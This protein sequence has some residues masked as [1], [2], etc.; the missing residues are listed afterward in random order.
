MNRKNLRLELSQLSSLVAL[1]IIP[2]CSLCIFTLGSAVTIC[3][4]S[5]EIPPDWE[6]ALI[7][8]VLLFATVVQHRLMMMQFVK[9]VAVLSTGGIFLMFVF[10]FVDQSPWIY[11]LGLA[12]FIVGIVLY[13]IRNVR[14][15]C[16]GGC[17]E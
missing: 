14:G 15:Y 7:G 2:K 12:L 17:K 4:I 10:L 5:P 1:I 16:S 3:G 6:Y 11:Y 9:N 8:G 13:L